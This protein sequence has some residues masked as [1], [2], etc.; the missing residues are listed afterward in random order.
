MNPALERLATALRAPAPWLA[1]HL[2]FLERS[3]PLVASASVAQ[4]LNEASNN[5]PCPVRF[6]D[7]AELPDDE[8]YEA[9]IARTGK[10]PTR[11]N[12]HDLLN[13]IVWL[14]Y[15]ATKRRLNVLQA[16]AITRAGIAGSRGEVRDALT[17][18]DE[19]GAILSAP[20]ELVGALRARDWH[21]LFVVRRELWQSAR[22]VLFGH[23]LLEKLLQP[24]KAIT[25]HVWIAEPSD[26]PLAATF[27]AARL[28]PRAFLPLP[29]LGVPG[30]W[31]ANEDPAF[32]ADVAV[33]RP[34]RVN[35]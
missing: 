5:R 13:G 19:N 23:A 25:A 18:F 32:Y 24:R 6:V 9:F 1:P 17:L 15:P 26:A 12:P 22:L 28:T 2:R 16:E 29:V 21:S 35:P 4:A 3:L 10:V 14:A 31:P 27:T 11:D 30:W 34:P 8:P 7:H 33:F 20:A